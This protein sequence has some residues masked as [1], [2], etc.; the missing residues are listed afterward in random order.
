MKFTA[1]NLEKFNYPGQAFLCCVLQASTVFVVEFINIW[2]LF[3]QA[4]VLDIIMNYIALGVISEFDDNFLMPFSHS[5]FSVFFGLQVRI[6]K[7]RKFKIY[8]DERT[9]LFIDR[10]TFDYIDNYRPSDS[11]QLRPFKGHLRTPDY[12]AI[13]AADDSDTQRSDAN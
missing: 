10:A 2:N 12:S 5:Q 1:L 11:S 9:P 13:Y 3:C 7:F 8:F 4:N 6:P